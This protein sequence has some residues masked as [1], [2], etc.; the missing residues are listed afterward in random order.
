MSEKSGHFKNGVWVE[1]PPPTAP[2]I[3]SEAIEKRL[4]EATKAVIA[5]ID[6]VMVVTHDLITSDDGRQYIEKSIREAEKQIQLSLDGI[7]SR[8]KA[9]VERTKIEMGKRAAEL[10]KKMK[11]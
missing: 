11:R 8:A 3:D 6:N 9:E 1:D 2:Q 7:V 5:S 4:S 10:E